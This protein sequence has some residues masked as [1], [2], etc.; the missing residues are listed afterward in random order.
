VKN[1]TVKLQ[2]N[3]VWILLRMYHAQELSQGKLLS[4]IEFALASR[5]ISYEDLKSKL[6]VFDSTMEGPDA[7]E[8]WLAIESIKN[9]KWFDR[10]KCIWLNNVF[11]QQQSSR[12][13]SVPFFLI[14]F[15]GR[16]PAEVL[17]QIKR[18]YDFVCLL[19]NHRPSR[20][21]IAR[22]IL[23]N[24]DPETYRLSYR[25]YL[26]KPEFD[27]VIGRMAPLH[28]D[29]AY[30]HDEMLGIPG[31][32]IMQAL[33]HLVAETSIQDDANDQ[34]CWGSKFV[35]EKTFK[36][37]DYRQMPLW[38]A[39]PNFVS[40][41]RSAGFD[42]FDDWFDNH[43]Y[44]DIQDQSQRFAKVFEILD[45]TLIRVRE[46]GGAE[47][48]SQQLSQRFDHNIAILNKLSKEKSELLSEFDQRLLT[49]QKIGC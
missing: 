32:A 17:N 10:T 25:T 20:S 49:L 3:C 27:E 35:T 6:L 46:Q 43:S 1:Q 45:R 34:N 33:I 15:A 19:R 8:F 13:F 26:L 23:D 18:K 9:E 31:D 48:V 5:R 44:D 40:H 4:D 39:V 22:R 42:L 11:V 24:Y 41:L 21:L 16:I 36:A 12:T 7:R 38:F 30:H 47:A 37:F 29:W 2:K 28:I 14:D